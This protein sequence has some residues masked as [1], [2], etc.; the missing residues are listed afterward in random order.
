MLRAFGFEI[1]TPKVLIPNDANL[2][3]T[4]TYEFDE[5][6]SIPLGWKK[7]FNSFDF[8][9]KSWPSQITNFI[10]KN[11][12]GV[13]IGFYPHMI[14]ESVKKL[15]IQIFI[16]AF[17]L[18][19]HE[20][21]SNLIREMDNLLKR[22]LEE[23][24]NIWFTYSYPQI[25]HNEE[26]WLK[27][28]SLFLPVGLDS[29][30]IKKYSHSW[31]P[32]LDKIF[33]VCPRISTSAYYQKIYHRFKYELGSFPH[34]I[35]G[36]QPISVQDKTVT[37]FLS[38]DDYYDLMRRCRLMF[39]HSQ[40]I[41][42]LHY[43]P[44]EAMIMG[45]PVIYMAN[46]CLDYMSGRSL[47]GRS[48]T[49]DEARY[50]INRILQGDEEFVKEVV[51]SQN[52]IVRHFDPEN[53]SQIW[54]KNFIPR[55]SPKNME[56][57]NIEKT[58]PSVVFWFNVSNPKQDYSIEGITRLQSFII[59]ACLEGEIAVKIACLSWMRPTVKKLLALMG[60]DVSRID[61]INDSP[62]PL[63]Y[64]L[65]ER[66]TE[67]PKAKKKRL[68]G[69]RQYLLLQYSLLKRKLRN[70]IVDARNF[71][72]VAKVTLVLLI[73]SPG[74]VVYLILF[75]IKKLIDKTRNLREKFV[76][77]I[78]G[79]R[80]KFNDKLLVLYFD[81]IENENLKMVRYRNKDVIAWFFAYP[82]FRLLSEIKA[83]KL[84]LVPD[85]VYLDYPLEYR[86]LIRNISDFETCI[87]EATKVVTFSKYVAEK[88]IIKN[89]LKDEEDVIVIQH[90]AVELSDYLK[91]DTDC[92][93]NYRLR[94]SIIIKDYLDL[95]FQKNPSNINHYASELPYGEFDYFFISSQVRPHKNYLGVI[96]AYSK[97]LREKYINYK[98][99]VTGNLDSDNNIVEF[100]HNNYLDFD[101]ISVYNLPP[102][103]HAAFYACASLTLVPTFF[104][105]GFP[106]VFFE[107]LSV[108]TPV[109]LSKIPVVEELLSQDLVRKICFDPFDLG[110]MIKK[111]E[112][113][114]NHKEYLLEIEMNVYKE[115]S[116]RTWKDA[117]LEY[118]SLIKTLRENDDLS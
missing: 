101:V 48:Q 61:F 62:I 78:T 83:P 28:K 84:V 10:N 6:L 59:K 89:G 90:G 20:S 116:K 77:Y 115:M 29:E 21:Y 92:N 39:Y 75:F 43:H 37:G 2:S 34:I 85:L 25:I 88:Q 41:R 5:S 73:I 71:Y 95:R 31:Q 3:T 100:I 12:D 52:F 54:E 96:N 99:I 118:L 15:N 30:F 76:N 97:L 58:K 109:L 67:P 93:I 44:I 79:L 9:S 23:K 113:A 70:M 81:M 112:W 108:G 57:D 24:D 38:D 106:F 32:E 1:F 16:R 82:K 13:M 60:C 63:V 33:F 110:D 111:M 27:Q 74:I 45:M 98:L 86:G 117:S 46:G 53:I 69:F 51:E 35:C 91:V 65:Y 80:S 4:I 19:G 50:K 104:E 42:H 14:R 72:D 47:P 26:E 87:R 105:G 102:V 55:I 11:F 49:Y 107:S 114:I 40:E 36:N 66:F 64:K 68:I 94:A 7:L 56:T 18:A 8:Y 17:G 103:V 22:R